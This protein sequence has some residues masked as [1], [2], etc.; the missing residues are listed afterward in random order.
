MIP[1][2][3]RIVIKVGT[4]VLLTDHEINREALA[5]IFSQVAL[6]MT[7]GI[8]C[9]IVLSGAVGRGKFHPDLKHKQSQASYGQLK[10]LWVAQDEAMKQG[11]DISLLLI[12]REDIVNRERYHSL[13]DTIYELLQANIAPIVNENDAT[14]PSH[15][16]D[17]TDNDRLAALLAISVGA[18]T[19]VLQTNADGVFTANPNTD[20]NAKLISEIH[21]FNNAILKENDFGMS[22]GGRGGMI[23][24]LKAARLATAAGIDTY[25]V[26]A[27]HKDVLKKLFIDEEQVGTKCFARNGCQTDFSRRARWIMSAHHSGASVQIDGGASMAVRSRKSLLAVGV[28]FLDG[29]FRAG[30]SIEVID[31]AGET[32]ALGLASIDSHT[33]SVA[34]SQKEPPFNIEVIHAD[35]L[36]LLS[37]LCAISPSSEPEPSAQA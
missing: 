33:L 7:R 37:V 36:I 26:G 6:L 25:I 3:K 16:H 22:Q 27:R 14:S 19:L 1:A 35:N 31:D 9:I 13:Q 24:K 21:V 11:V 2:M 12:S 17:F 8:Q 28:K 30:E 10:V 18:D 4:N 32:I 23:G 20:A 29:N 15:T 34:L 5:N